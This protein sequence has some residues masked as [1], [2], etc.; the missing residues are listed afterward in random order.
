MP[1]FSDSPVVKF[2]KFLRYTGDFKGQLTPLFNKVVKQ[3]LSRIRLVQDRKKAGVAPI[4]NF[5]KNGDRFHFF[6]ELNSYHDGHFLEEVMTLTE[7]KDLDGL[8]KLINDAVTEIMNQNFTISLTL[9][10]VR[11]AIWHLGNHFLLTV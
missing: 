4:A 7:A 2:I 8:N 11:V 5:D 9:T 1:I 10:L 6:P 3:E